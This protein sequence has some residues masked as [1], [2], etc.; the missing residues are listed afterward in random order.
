[1]RF[2]PKRV[3]LRPLRDPQ[4]QPNGRL[5]PKGAHVT[6]WIS[7]LDLPTSLTVAIV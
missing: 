3:R 6:M 4:F 5:Q 2:E 7:G 1:M